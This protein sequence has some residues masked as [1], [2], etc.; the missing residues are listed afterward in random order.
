MTNVWIA[1]TDGTRVAVEA[2]G[3]LADPKQGL[4]IITVQRDDSSVVVSDVRNGV[5][6]TPLKEGRIRIV[7]ADGMQVRL[8]STTGVE[9]VFDAEEGRFISPVLE[10]LPTLTASP[11]PVPTPVPL[12]HVA[13][14]SI[15]MQVT[16]RSK[17][18][19][20]ESRAIE[21]CTAIGVGE[22]VEIDV[23]LSGLPTAN[24]RN[25]GLGAFQFT[26]VY[27]ETK[28][29]VVAADVN[30]LL[31][32]VSGS[33]PFAVTEPVT[34]EEA[35]DGTWIIG[36]LDAGS[37]APELA[38]KSDGVLARITLEG[39]AAGVSAVALE[40]AVVLAGELPPEP[41]GGVALIER[42]AAGKIAVGVNCP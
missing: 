40:D 6:L 23:V 22:R 28:L 37:N 10:P 14:A 38:E 34:S 4:L 30:M 29:K 8:E 33:Q 16:D 19:V 36:A 9:F 12:P 15:D 18:E 3:I 35:N 42:T 20:T 24:G 25:L 1:A 32:S 2:G 17:A 27:D 41:F 21:T 31:A 26:L 5:H 39:V 11:T 7:G 13:L